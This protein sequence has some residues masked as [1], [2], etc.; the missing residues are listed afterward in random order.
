M[1]P[2]CKNS[3]TEFSTG[4]FIYR[5]QCPAVKTVSRLNYKTSIQQPNQ[6]P[7]GGC[8]GLG[9]AA[10][11]I[12]GGKVVQRTEFMA[13]IRQTLVKVERHGWP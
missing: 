6:V 4:R 1:L 10:K 12:M 5:I 7:L 3:M 2:P 8:G 11:E 13:R 9:E